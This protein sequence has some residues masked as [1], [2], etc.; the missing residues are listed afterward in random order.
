MK[1]QEKLKQ[2]NPSLYN[3]FVGNVEK[4]K[5]ILEKATP[6]E[7]T[8]HGYEHSV[9]LEKYAEHLLNDEIINSLSEDEL[10]ILLHGIY[11]HDIGMI[12]YC[13]E[14]VIEYIQKKDIELAKKLKKLVEEN[15]ELKDDT[16]ILKV[17]REEHNLLS[18]RMIY[19]SNYEYDPRIISLPN[20]KYA[21]SIALVCLGHRDY[22]IGN[23]KINTLEQINETE[24][25]P[26]VEPYPNGEVNTRFLACIVRLADEL[27]ITYQRAKSDILLHIKDSLTKRSLTEWVNHDL[28][29]MVKIDNK[30]HKITFFPNNDYILRTDKEIGDRQITRNAIFAKQEKVQ[31]ELNTLYQYYYTD[32]TEPYKLGYGRIE[33]E[34]DNTVCTEND[35][36]KYLEARKET[37]KRLILEDNIDPTE[38]VDKT[39]GGIKVDIPVSGLEQEIKLKRK[40]LQ[41]IIEQ[42]YERES[43]ISLGNF[44]LPS[45]FYTRY[46]FNTNQILPKSEILNLV[47]DIFAL[48]F[49]SKEIDCVV[50]IDKAGQI[51]APNLSLKL[52]CNYTYL[53]HSN[54]VKYSVSFEKGCSIKTANNIL[55]I[56]DVISTGKTIKS[57]IEKLKGDFNPTKIF[58]AGIFTSNK[59]ACESISSIDNIELLYLNDKYCFKT[60]SPEEVENDDTLK[61]EFTIL[62]S[63]KK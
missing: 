16:E 61:N 41:T 35:Y 54:E 48:S 43:L 8:F 60:Y 24:P 10:F 50:G 63:V 29:S 42:L 6:F 5:V 44:I 47:T 4:V 59:S 34:L 22:K 40:E 45:G 9:Q 17:N 18:F 38:A 36:S 49:S 46:Y 19:P 62:K 13:R 56:T 58:V 23:K 55:I 30:F 39:D 51:L 11:Y 1:L 33:I 37:T 27:D 3:H 28:I 57:A 15:P 26:K 52:K 12:K 14:S 53:I 25:F 31:S 21:K 7:Y 20:E 32:A 2:L